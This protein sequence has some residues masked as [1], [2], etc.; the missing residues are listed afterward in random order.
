MLPA[1]RDLDSPPLTLSLLL[2]YEQALQVAERSPGDP[3][4]SGFLSFCSIWARG[5]DPCGHTVSVSRCRRNISSNGVFLEMR[6][7]VSGDRT[8]TF[9]ETMQSFSGGGA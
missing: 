7:G 5:G 4:G 9:L 2:G 8:R 3:E 6:H 1:S